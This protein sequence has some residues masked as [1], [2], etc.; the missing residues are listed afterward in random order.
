MVSL[1]LDRH[2]DTASLMGGMEGR[3]SVKRKVRSH[4]LFG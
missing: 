3:W 1:V 4:V 2:P